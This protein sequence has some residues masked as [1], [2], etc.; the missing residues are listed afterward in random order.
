MPSIRH[1]TLF[2]AMF[3]FAAGFTSIASAS[4][5]VRCEACL[6][7]YSYCMSQPGASETFCVY[8]YNLCA[9]ANGCLPMPI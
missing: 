1:K 4:F 2:A 9:A 6:N 3:V 5:N 7:N 8:E